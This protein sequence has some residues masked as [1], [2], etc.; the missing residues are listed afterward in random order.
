MTPERVY[1]HDESARHMMSGMLEVQQ[2]YTCN[3]THWHG[4]HDKHDS[5]I[6][7]HLIYCM[8][9]LHRTLLQPCTGVSVEVKDIELELSP[10]SGQAVFVGE[11]TGTVVFSTDEPR[12]PLISVLLLSR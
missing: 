11:V 5:H 6:Y 7:I 12:N 8:H 10:I 2:T 3:A 4:S 1:K 9:A